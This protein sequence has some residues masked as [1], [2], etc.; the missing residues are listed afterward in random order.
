MSGGSA[1]PR[2]A[3]YWA[4]SCGGCEVSVLNIGEKIME[5]DRAFEIVF[6]PCLADFK[7]EDVLNYPDEH[8]DLCLFNGA[9]RSDENE[10]MAHLLRRKSRIMV[11]YGS[12]AHEGCVP[13]MANLSTAGRIL[14]AVYRR[15]ESTLNP[16]GL[17][18]ATRS[19]VPEG[20]IELPAFHDTVRTLGQVVDVDFT[21]PGCPPESF[22]VWE[23]LH[24]LA[25]SLRYGA[26]LPEPGSVIG[27]GTRALCEECPLERRSRPVR[28]FYRP[29]EITPTPGTCLLEQGLVCLGPATR[30]GCGALCPQACMGCRGCYGPPE[31]VE[32]QGAA[33]V[34]ALAAAVDAGSP[35]SGERNLKREVEE[36]MNTIVDPA[37]TFYRFS[38]GDSLLQRARLPRDRRE[39]EKE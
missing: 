20:Q 31:G 32:D 36:A 34:A 24:F 38:M 13:A 12:C 7:Q 21:V 11:A 18:P 1:K 27:A 16:A 37:G 15:S 30:G 9:I 19:A 33:A 6:L 25:V 4:S 2:L 3:M 14:D 39:G 10:E 28:R 26:R 8:I 35:Q 22:R 17:V 23:V 5:I 29:Y